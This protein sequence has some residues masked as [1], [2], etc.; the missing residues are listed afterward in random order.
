MGCQRT[1][2]TSVKALSKSYMLL[3]LLSLGL[4]FPLCARAIISSKVPNR[5]GRETTL[6]ALKQGPLRK[7]VNAGWVSPIN[8]TAKYVIVY[9]NDG[10]MP[11]KLD[12]LHIRKS[13]GFV[14]QYLRNSPLELYSG[15]KTGLTILANYN[16][17]LPG[18]FDR[19]IVFYDGATNKTLFVADIPPVS[20]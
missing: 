19:K 2:L 16:G 5:I 10:K 12:S 3:I 15:Q 17:V 20:I 1:P 14:L 4:M 8:R 9:R 6:F 7:V 18:L 11:V 13:A